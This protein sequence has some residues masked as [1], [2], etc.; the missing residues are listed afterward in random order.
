MDNRFTEFSENTNHL[1]RQSASDG[2]R[3]PSPGRRT[4]TSEDGGDW[5]RSKCPHT[6]GGGNLC[7]FPGVLWQDIPQAFTHVHTLP[8]S[9][10]WTSAPKYRLED[11]L[12]I[13]FHDK[14]LEMMNGESDRPW[15]QQTAGHWAALDCGFVDTRVDAGNGHSVSHRNGAES[16]LEFVGVHTDGL[17]RWR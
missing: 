14:K 1:R 3:R 11:S 4:K 5:T 2:G 17:P 9:G 12:Q 15:L 13:I 10:W 7:G 8:V 6:T 16:V